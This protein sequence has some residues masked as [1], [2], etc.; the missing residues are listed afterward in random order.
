MAKINDQNVGFKS[1]NA[2]AKNNDQNLKKTI[3]IIFSRSKSGSKSPA[4][5]LSASQHRRQSQMQ[6]KIEQRQQLQSQ[7]QTEPVCG[8]KA[9]KSVIQKNL[10]KNEANLDKI[11]EN[12]K[13]NIHA[14]PKLSQVNNSSPV[15][16]PVEKGP[17]AMPP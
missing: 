9:R 10:K 8:F 4:R 11:R 2:I 5:S 14:A 7:R 6:A 17:E 15:E 16:R 13:K 3:N 12:I 1:F